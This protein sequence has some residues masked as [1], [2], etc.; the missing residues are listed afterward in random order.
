[1]KF[2]LISLLPFGI[3]KSTRTV[4]LPYVKDFDEGRITTKAGQIQ[5]SEETMEFC[6]NEIEDLLRKD[7]IRKSKSPWS[8]LPF[9]VQKNAELERGAPRLV[10]NYKLLNKVLKWI[11]YPIANK[12]NLINRLSGSVLTLLGNM[13]G[14]QYL[15]ILRMPQVSSKIS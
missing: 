9:Y 14:M 13:N 11:R 1:V 6:R 15:L 4:S 5:M 3:G 12:R 10:I 2:V 8:C 7:I